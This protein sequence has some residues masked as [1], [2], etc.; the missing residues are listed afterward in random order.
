V[1]GEVLAEPNPDVK[2]G[3]KFVIDFD[4]TFLRGTQPITADFGP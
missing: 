2:S 1:D 3:S 4:G